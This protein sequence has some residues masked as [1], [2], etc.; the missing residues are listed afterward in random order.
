M[1][2]LLIFKDLKHF[3][4]KAVSVVLLQHGNYT[5]VHGLI[6]ARAIWREKLGSDLTERINQLFTMGEAVVHDQENLCMSFGADVVAKVFPP[7]VESLR[8]GPCLTLV[9]ISELQ[10]AVAK[11][12]W[13]L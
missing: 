13:L 9:V 6:Y 4:K 1:E 11:A 3:A 8:V 2:S 7:F 10:S 12:S 5:A